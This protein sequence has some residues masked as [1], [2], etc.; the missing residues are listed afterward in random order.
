LASRYSGPER[1]EALPLPRR[2]GCAPIALCGACVRAA[3]AMCR[4]EGGG[5]GEVARD[6]GELAR[7]SDA[8]ERADEERDEA[9][10]EQ[11]PVRAL[12]S[13]GRAGTEEEQT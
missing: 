8:T 12:L 6:D 4:S 10:E 11:E 2:I 3:A 1:D 13:G 7:E 5:E 9:A